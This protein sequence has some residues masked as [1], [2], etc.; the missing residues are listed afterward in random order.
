M[1][2]RIKEIAKKKGKTQG[3]ISKEIDAAVITIAS[4]YSQKRQPSLFNLEKIGRFLECDPL[5]LL[6]PGN[7]Y[8]HFYDEN[9]IWQGIR[10]K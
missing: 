4:Y 7:G 2:N 1:E 3:D 10:K 9:N 6:M 5:E 8:A